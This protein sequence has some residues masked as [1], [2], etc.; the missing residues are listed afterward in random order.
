MLRIDDRAEVL[1]REEKLRH[2]KRRRGLR[3]PRITRIER[4]DVVVLQ[5]RRTFFERTFF[6]MPDRDRSVTLLAHSNRILKHGSRET[7]DER[8]AFP[9]EE[10]GALAVSKLGR[11][12]VLRNEVL[13]ELALRAG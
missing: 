4:Y 12:L 3:V 1:G 8:A 9:R 11:K 6:E 5:T 10:R 2:A 7:V 13:G